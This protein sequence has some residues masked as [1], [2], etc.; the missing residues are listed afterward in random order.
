MHRDISSNFN[1][2]AFPNMSGLW[3]LRELNINGNNLQLYPD[4]FRSQ[5]QLQS[6]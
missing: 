4:T 3:Q 1:L 5:T 2:M 6:L